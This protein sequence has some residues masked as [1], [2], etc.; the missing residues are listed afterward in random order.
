MSD[1]RITHVSIWSAALPPRDEAPLNF[2]WHMYED[3]DG[4]WTIEDWE[5]YDAQQE[6]WDWLDGEEEDDAE[7]A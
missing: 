7:N 3:E 4:E 1:E 2:G 5:T 6:Y